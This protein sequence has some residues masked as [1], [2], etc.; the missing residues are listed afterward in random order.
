MSP[1]GGSRREVLTSSLVKFDASL[2]RNAQWMSVYRLEYSIDHSFL[3]ITSADDDLSG[4]KV[5]LGTTQ[6]KLLDQR[7]LESWNYS[8]DHVNNQAVV[9]NYLYTKWKLGLGYD[10]QVWKNYRSNL[11]VDYS[12]QGYSENSNNRSDNTIGLSASL[13]KEYWPSTYVSYSAQYN[14]NN[15]N[16]D[17]YQYDKYVLS[18][19]I[20]H[21]GAGK[22][23]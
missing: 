13:S 1:S 21:S 12:W 17:T 18:V 6:T 11:K 9:K 2:M 8:I 19:S 22:K 7:G 4:T 5:S 14:L 10:N 20:S 15:S 23:K 16:V 3:D